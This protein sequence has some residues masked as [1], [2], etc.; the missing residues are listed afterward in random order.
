MVK[1]LSFSTCGGRHY[2]VL[3]EDGIVDLSARHGSRWPTLREVIEAGVLAQLAQEA[4]GLAADVPLSSI[5]Y[6]I[7]IPSPEK[8]ICVGVNFPDRNEEYKDGRLRRPI[9]RS[10]SGFPAPSPGM[11]A[12]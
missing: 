2:G 10:S 6:E 5:T 4:A 8:I 9:P 7:P 1:F 12:R 3:K 11:S